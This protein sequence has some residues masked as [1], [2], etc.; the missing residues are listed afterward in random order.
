MNKKRFDVFINYD[1]NIITQYYI[2]VFD[3]KIIIKHHKVMFSKNEQWK[4]EF[5]NL[6][7]IT[8]NVLFNKRSINKSRKTVIIFELVVVSILTTSIFFVVSKTLM[9]TTIENID[10]NIK[11][12]S[13][14]IEN[15]S[16]VD[17][18][19]VESTI[20]TRAKLTILTKSRMTH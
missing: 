2:W 11:Q 12:S 20:Q 1:E 7:T 14:E 16:K 8:M 4:N 9:S 5:L 19:I 6:F 18:L 10:D 17:K 15:E 3:R 13:N